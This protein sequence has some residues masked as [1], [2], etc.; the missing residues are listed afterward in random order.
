[1]SPA[2]MRVEKKKKV[3]KKHQGKLSPAYNRQSL[4]AAAVINSAATRDVNEPLTIDK[5]PRD[6]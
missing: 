5:L 1:M 6:F 3:K 2:T 4:C